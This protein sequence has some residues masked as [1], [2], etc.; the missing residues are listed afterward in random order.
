MLGLGGGVVFV[1]RGM[2]EEG[3]VVGLAEWEVLCLKVVEKTRFF[4]GNLKD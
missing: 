3:R 2:G 4:L 1:L